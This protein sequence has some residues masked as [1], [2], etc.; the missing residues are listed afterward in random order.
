MNGAK[1]LFSVWVCVSVGAPIGCSTSSSNPGPDSGPMLDGSAA[2]AAATACDPFRI[3]LCPQ[4]QTCCF[5]GLGGTCMDVGSCGTPFRIACVN[6]STCTGGSTCCGSIQGPA[7][8]A[9]AP[10]A[11]VDA[12]AFAVTL[13]CESQSTCPAPEFQICMT[14]ADCPSGQMCGMGGMMAG[15]PG[16]PAI[17]ACFPL[18]AGPAAVPDGGATAVDAADAGAA[19]GG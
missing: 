12:A 19:D 18:D 14:S 13:A 15:P 4:G 8:D 1:L 16:F 7:G 11:A 9:A 3:E 5:S 6:A 10:D 17:L 2:E